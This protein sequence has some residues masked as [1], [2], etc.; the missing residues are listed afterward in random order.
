MSAEFPLTRRRLLSAG[1]AVTA[2]AVGMPGRVLAGEPNG[3]RVL[4]ARAAAAPLRGADKP[5]TPISGYDGLAPGPTLR[6]RRGEEIKVRLINELSE[7][8]SVHWHG[9]RL[10]NAMDGTALIQAPIAPGGSF[11]YRF[12]PPDAGTFWYHPHINGSRQVGRGL[13]GL[14]IVDEAA[15]VTVDRDVALVLADWTLDAAGAIDIAADGCSPGFLTVNGQPALDIPVRSNERLR[16]RLLNATRTRPLALRLDQHRTIVMAI[17]G[18]PAEPFTARDSRV[19]LGPG[20]R[21]DLFVDLTLA[22]GSR[23]A[24]LA[25][26]P[27]GTVAL[28]TLVYEAGSPT[29]PSPLPDPSPLPANPLP[30]RID[31][32]AALRPDLRLDG[33]DAVTGAAKPLFSAKRGRT[34]TLALINRAASASVVHVHGHSVRLLDSLDDG[35]KPFWLDTILVPGQQTLRVAFVADN[36]GKWTIDCTSLG[37]PD[38]GAPMWFEVL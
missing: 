8:T 12:T 11:D 35:W 2:F 1:I 27:G 29:R 38:A 19:V 15:P 20:N 36:P 34:V 37:Q 6:Y 32:R 26:V 5:A 28:A 7:P 31:L 22:P 3:F 24:I 17:D 23:A 33:P 30:E 13:S 21:I 10:A 9:V 16:L 4:R 18:E 14:L 25:D